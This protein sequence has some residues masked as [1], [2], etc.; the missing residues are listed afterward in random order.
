MARRGWG[1]F[2]VPVASVWRLAASPLN[3]AG[4]EREAVLPSGTAPDGAH[5]DLVVYLTKKTM[6]LLAHDLRVLV[7]VHRMMATRRATA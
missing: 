6:F 3:G 4:A 2:F 7:R 1:A 5:N